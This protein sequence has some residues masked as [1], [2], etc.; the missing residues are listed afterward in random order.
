M[1]LSCHKSESMRNAGERK[2]HCDSSVH[3]FILGPT[4]GYREIFGAEH[5]LSLCPYLLESTD[6]GDG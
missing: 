1:S 2:L 5:L 3:A 4:K 6:A